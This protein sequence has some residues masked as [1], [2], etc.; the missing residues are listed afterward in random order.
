[1][2]SITAFASSTVPEVTFDGKTEEFSYKNTDIASNGNPDLFTEI[3]GAIP[4]DS[5]TQEIELVVK[6]IEDETVTI[7][8]YSES[9]NEDYEILMSMVEF[10]ICYD[11]EEVEA[12][13]LEDGITLGE[14]TADDTKEFTAELYIPITVGNEISALSAEI[15][16]IFVAEIIPNED[17]AST[18]TSKEPEI[19]PTPTDDT[20]VPQTGDVNKTVLWTALSA[21]SIGGIVIIKA[22]RQT[23]NNC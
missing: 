21:I 3:K 19:T 2:I 16:W 18:S 6:N 12:G 1:M 20:E 23:H 5:F 7:L 13:T 9:D 10:T 17:E 4:G 22:K 14:F 15:D 8:L 11:G